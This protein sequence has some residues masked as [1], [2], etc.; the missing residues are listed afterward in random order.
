MENYFTSLYWSLITVFQDFKQSQIKLIKME[1]GIFT[2]R[3]T[4]ILKKT[5]KTIFKASTIATTSIK[6]VAEGTSWLN[7][8]FTD[9][10]KKHERKKQQEMA[11]DI[12]DVTKTVLYDQDFH[13]IC[14]RTVVNVVKVSSTNKMKEPKLRRFK[15]FIG[16]GSSTKNSISYQLKKLGY[17]DFQKRLTVLSQIS[18]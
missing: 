13:E 10:Y 16:F 1:L 3:K 9:I 2:S 18:G 17:D 5:F 11:E 7:W 14:I 15:F 4:H 8:I 12:S 6:G